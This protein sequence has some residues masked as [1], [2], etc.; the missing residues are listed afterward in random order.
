MIGSGPALSL[1]TNPSRARHELDALLREVAWPGDAEGAVLAVHEALMNADRHAGGATQA[2]ARIDG[3][4]VVVEIHDGGPG[5]DLDGH[6][7]HTP[8]PL[9]ERGRGLWLI[10][11]IADGWQVDRSHGRTCLRLRFE[12]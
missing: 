5:F 7:R 6:A 11:Q 1:S 4:T 3:S 12:S 9:A 8:D 2:V 10:S